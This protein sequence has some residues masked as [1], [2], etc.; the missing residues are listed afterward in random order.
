V[1]G[2][3]S[4]RYHK[5]IFEMFPSID[6]ALGVDDLDRVAQVV[7]ELA[8]GRRGFS[9]V[10]T[11][12]PDRLF[13]PTHPTLVL[14][15]KPHAYLKIGEGCN[16]ACAFCAIPGIRGRHRSRTMRELVEEAQAL[17]SAGFRELD[18]ISQDLTGYGKDLADGSS[19]VKLLRELDQLDGDFWLRI[20]YAY[21]T[22]LSDELLEWM[23][24][25]KHGCR[26]IDVPIQ[27]SH[28]DIL[29][30]MRR[31]STTPHLTNLA[32]RLRAAVPG[33]TLRT[34]VLLGFP[35][36]TDAHFRHLREYIEE[37]RFDHLGAFAFSPE[38]GTAA[39]DM[40]ATP[41]A[42]TADHR[43]NTIMEEQ[44]KIV[45]SLQQRHIGQTQT[46][47]LEAPYFEDG[48]Q[49]EG[50]WIGRSQAQA[51]DDIDG[52]T[53]VSEVPEGAEAGDFARVIVENIADYDLLARYLDEHD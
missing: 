34:T 50:M 27:H 29:R 52:F 40:G 5:R 8:A 46:V 39:A 7:R 35:G 37:A 16:H 47:L 28:P 12:S 32:Q 13:A 33:V 31:A 21:P 25:S 2:C 53:L 45:E 19:L 48:E 24:T 42:Q 15:G 3:F 23:A 44:F 9:A 14:T 51:P 4:Q 30:A 49:L 10:S 20:L 18:L 1:T 26:Y 38:E 11:E 41:P 6:A 22:G 43:Q 36:E 17:I